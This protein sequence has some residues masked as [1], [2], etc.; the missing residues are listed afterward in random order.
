[1][2]FPGSD[3][4]GAPFLSR[5]AFGQN[6][7][8][9]IQANFGGGLAEEFTN[10]YASRSPPT[11]TSPQGRGSSKHRDRADQLM[12]EILS[13]T[14]NPDRKKIQERRDALI[15]QLEQELAGKL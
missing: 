11:P 2:E 6:S 10:A 12:E 1:M 9:I 3:R 5:S 4:T 14:L 13:K 7:G 15:T 8:E